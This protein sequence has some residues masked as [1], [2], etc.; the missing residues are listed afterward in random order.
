MNKLE[1]AQK[2]YD[3]VLEADNKAQAAYRAQLDYNPNSRKRL[4]LQGATITARRVLNDAQRELDAA[5][6]ADEPRSVMC[7]ICAYSSTATKS[8]LAANG[9]IFGGGQEICP[10]H[11]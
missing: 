9:W 7:D 1:R 5:K 10:A 4:I 2:N 8:Y 3:A 6:V 11:D